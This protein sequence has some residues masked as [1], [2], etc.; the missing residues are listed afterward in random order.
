MHPV[1]RHSSTPL[2]PTAF[3][4]LSSFQPVTGNL[5]KF[6]SFDLDTTVYPESILIH[7]EIESIYTG[8]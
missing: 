2:L 7:S 1:F 8:P 5:A 3:A 6:G 4:K